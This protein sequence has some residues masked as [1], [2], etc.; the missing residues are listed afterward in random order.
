MISANVSINEHAPVTALVL[1]GSRAGQD[2]VAQMRGVSNK[3]VA[4]VGG[5]PMI[6]RV[7]QTL[8][9]SSIVGKKI[10]CGPS[11]DTIQNHSFLK[12]MIESGQVLWVAPRKGPS[13]S[14]RTVLSEHSPEFPLFITTADHVLL[15]VEMVEYFIREARQVG[16]DVVV[17][18][19][20]FALVAKSYPRSKRTVTRF[21]GQGFCGC[22]LFLLCTPKSERLV[23]FWSH[24]E[25]ER[26]H[27]WR[28]IRALGV[29]E[30]V[31]YILGRLTL[32]EALDRLGRRLDLHVKEILVPFAE[33]AIDVDSLEDL[34]LA[35]EILRDRS[36]V[37]KEAFQG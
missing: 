10:L 1:A 23:E 11:W 4:T 31:R 5:E 6:S 22:N 17:G 32:M 8:E 26:K 29:T 28:L 13:E 19:V 36:M 14:V 34:T 3:A 24:L 2:P 21:S 35:E 12:S 18:L 27:P 25:R 7:V 30:L 37:K 15:T 33:A 20:P 16:A 9:K